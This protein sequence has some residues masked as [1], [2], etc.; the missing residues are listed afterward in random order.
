MSAV[1]GLRNEAHFHLESLQSVLL[2][3]EM[4]RIRICVQ[5]TRACM[6]HG[7]PRGRRVI[8]AICTISWGCG[9][10]RCRRQAAASLR[11]FMEKSHHPQ[12]TCPASR[13]LPFHGCG[14]TILGDRCCDSLLARIFRFE[15]VVAGSPTPAHDVQSNSTALVRTTVSFM[16]TAA[17]LARC[18]WPASYSRVR[19]PGSRAMQCKLWA[20]LAYLIDAMCAAVLQLCS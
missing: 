4:G 19:K 12:T 16:K 10:E 1:V 3:L 5:L 17:K 8:S 18:I 7:V 14:P 20:R 11:S 6:E 9:G 13:H 2:E 15:T